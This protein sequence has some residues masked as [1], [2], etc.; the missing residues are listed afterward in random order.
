MHH[1]RN[2]ITMT[3]LRALLMGALLAIP[4]VHGQA[5][6]PQYLEPTFQIPNS[7]WLGSGTLG[8][9][10]DFDNDGAEELVLASRGS[11]AW[12][13]M[14]SP[15]EW[16]SP[17]IFNF[18]GMFPGPPVT[19]VFIRTG[20]FDG[21][22]NQDV[23]IITEFIG[24]TI[25]I[26]L[27]D[28]AGGFT[29]PA[30]P[31]PIQGYHHWI[32]VGDFD[33]DGRSDFVVTINPTPGNTS[34]PLERHLYLS[35][36]PSWL[37]RGIIPDTTLPSN[38]I[39][40]AGDFDGDGNLDVAFGSSNRSFYSG[41]RVAYGDGTGTFTSSTWYQAAMVGF[42]FDVDGDGIDDLLSE[43]ASLFGQQLVIRYGTQR[44][45]LWEQRF[46]SLHW[47]I[48]GTLGL[49]VDDVDR[50]G[51]PDIIWSAW[52]Y[53]R[54]PATTRHMIYKNEGGR[55]FSP[56]TMDVFPP[57]AASLFGVPGMTIADFDG[58]GDSDWVEHFGSPSITYYTNRARYHPGCGGPGTTSPQITLTGTTL[59]QPMTLGIG[60]APAGLQGWLAV[61][62]AQAA[63]LPVTCL[64]A[65]DLMT[66]GAFALP[67][68]VDPTGTASLTF[69]L[70]AGPALHGTVFF[71]QW[72]AADPSGMPVFSDARTIILW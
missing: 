56:Q 19:A 66:P 42:V 43:D 38:V 71:T 48:E 18:N 51:H 55:R 65:I 21:D 8:A 68:A 28:G 17:T 9:T 7:P 30:G 40:N 34:T 67:L 25:L 47:S 15:A 35:R 70:P 52:S 20:D 54:Q 22:G 14:G 53:T 44:R 23:L 57:G 4:A 29:S 16:G 1:N 61:S 24:P 49:Y 36:W 32:A 63:P 41:V 31:L 50:D 10:A 26:Y 59:G 62:P 69:T 58:D 3:T 5:P 45:R 13:Y 11:T 60:S 46:P 33:N 2:T 12:A 6:A 37:Y 72:G 64:P 27:G 39:V